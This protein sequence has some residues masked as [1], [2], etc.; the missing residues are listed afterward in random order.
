MN[1]QELIK[2]KI[3]TGAGG[4]KGSQ[5]QPIEA[6][7]TLQSRQTIK[8]Q[9]LLSEG[10]VV[11]IVGNLK[12]VFLDGTPIQNQTG[13][14]NFP[15]VKFDF[16]SGT[17]SQT[18][19]EGF[20]AVESVSVV[21]TEIADV[22]IVRSTSDGNVDAVRIG[23]R[24]PALVKNDT[25]NGDSVGYRIGLAFEHRVGSG[26]WIPATTTTITGKNL[27]PYE[28]AFRIERPTGTSG[29]W[30]VRVRRTT[31]K[32]DSQAIQ[33]TAIWYT[34]TEIQDIKV[35]Y[36]D[37]ALVGLYIDAEATGGAIP[38]RSYLFDGIICQV[39]TT[40]NPTVYNSDGTVQSYA[41]WSSS[42]WNGTFKWSWTDDPAWILYDLLTN[43]R[44]GFGKYIN[45]STIDIYDFWAASRY[46]TQLIPKS[47][48]EPTVLE[49][50]FTFNTS[51]PG[52]EDAFKV[53]QSIAA[54][55]RA[56]LWSAPGYIRL[57]QDRPTEATAFIN[58]SNVIDGKF[59]YSGSEL[60][61]RVT[62][63]V[64]NFIDKENDYA[65]RTIKEEASSTLISKYGYNNQEISPLGVTGEGQ[66][67]RLA[68]WVLDTAMSNYDTVSF[69]VS[70]NNALMEIGDVISISD[71]WYAGEQFSGQLVPIS[72]GTVNQI[73]FD[74]TLSLTAGTTILFMTFDGIEQE[75]TIQTT[76]TGT[77]FAL[78]PKSG[79]LNPNAYPN[80][81][82]SV[83][84]DVSPRLFK[85]DAIAQT[86]VGIYDITATEYDPNKYA[87]V[88]S[89]IS[90]TPPLFSS[91][92]GLNVQ[93]PQNLAVTPETY[94]DPNGVL[95][96]RLNFDW[97]DNAEYVKEYRLQYRRNNLPFEWAPSTL[98]SNITLTECETGIYEYNLYAYNTRG[99][100]SPAT[101]GWFELSDTLEGV[102][103]LAAPEDLMLAG[104]GT[105]FN[106]AE[107]TI[108]WTA[109]ESIV[110]TLL[111]DYQIKV[112]SGVNS[113]SGTLIKT[114]YQTETTRLFTRNEIASWA[115][116]ENP[117]RNIYIE[118]RARDTFN[119]V[120]LPVFALFNNPAPVA[121]TGLVLT[122]FFN[123]YM[124]EQ[125]VS[126]VA[127]ITGVVIHHSTTSGFTPSKDNL[128]LTGANIPT[129][130]IPGDENT[131][132]YVR[133]AY[134]DTWSTEDLIYS[135]QDS[136][137]TQSMDVGIT[138]TAPSGLS[139]SSVL[140][141]TSP[142]VYQ[143]KVTLSWTRSVN[144][145]SYDLEI[146]STS[147]GIAE[148]PQVSQPDS[149]TVT[150]TFI[151]P[152]ATAFTFRIRSRAANSVS[153]WSS[154][155][156]HTTLA[157]TVAP[158]APTTL[159]G[160][161]GFNSTSLSWV[162]P[163][164]SDL[165]GIEI[166]RR[167]G[168]GGT[169]TKIGTV[170]SRT[171]FYIDDG[172]TPGTDYRYRIRAFD[173]S[174]NFSGYTALV[175]VTAVGI[176]NG[177]VTTTTI[178]DNAITTP[179]IVSNAIVTSHMAANSINGDRI[180]ANTLNA[181]KIVSN[182]ITAT[183]IAAGT[184]T[185]TEIN[186][187]SVRAAILVA[188]SITTTMLQAGSITASEVASNQIITNNAN[189]ANGVIV[190]AHIANATIA[191]AKIANATIGTAQIADASITNAKIGGDIQSTATGQGG[192]PLWK[193]ARSGSLTMTG[194]NSGG[195]MTLDSQKMVVYDAAG[196]V[197]VKLGIW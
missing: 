67:R 88:E 143:A 59:N 195:W 191:G 97:D 155:V 44:Y 176:P 147:A 193:L 53:L 184:I 92:G 77:Q 40:Y 171:N 84:K 136:V 7:N 133:I 61:G 109:T 139:A 72:G 122:A 62:S 5:R 13:D 33:D 34:T 63:C 46:N 70:W 120:S 11:G 104:G 130:L 186:A 175:A 157:D 131:T 169:E 3:I 6:P 179:K 87:R 165:A 119:R 187:S 180:T 8:V 75:R 102:S 16:R 58:N 86:E 111:K 55:F 68:K 127:D 43:E 166:Y 114:L 115:N 27:S 161:S 26:A 24:I 98:T 36:P 28:Q 64:V 89:G 65:P 134:T 197:R 56:V 42:T 148:F 188:D 126:T 141:E 152:V 128:V 174:G 29:V 150:Y 183:Q 190:N 194:A 162:N 167:I 95:K 142:G 45:T 32:S 154:V 101:S 2:S 192:L 178:T 81:P 20:P 156:N 177:A 164:A 158:S 80:A 116:R 49:P 117:S 78:V 106:A 69:R 103:P 1:P 38:G 18:Y 163:T 125:N 73:K 39:P 181:N 66:A 17:S 14:F 182:S 93:A 23:I 35:A 124:L 22:P 146:L 91:I 85:I 196:T 108:T 57:I 76:A 185:A 83:L 94:I 52:R 144:V 153:V 51:I 9:E 107:F 19:M 172:L 135:P 170:G 12:G 99:V 15:G 151:A 60:V 96:Y 50:R 160:Y 189:I 138:P 30:S 140:I 10:E 21:N 4:G 149:G 74:R 37:A 90:I 159:T 173:V 48:E 79:A 132:Y 112:Y 121:P 41:S 168:A 145:S 123:Q 105:T 113:V 110:G 118:V 31:A 129:Y 25:T 100:Q 47:V 137:T 82:Y 54:S 71:N